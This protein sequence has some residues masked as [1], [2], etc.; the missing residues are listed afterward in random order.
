MSSTSAALEEPAARRPDQTALIQGTR[1]RSFSR[2]AEEA[3]AFAAAMQSNW[4][5]ER[6][7]V[8]AVY[9]PNCIEFVIAYFAAGMIGATVVPIDERLKRDEVGHILRDSGA[10]FAIVHAKLASRL[11]DCLKDGIPLDGIRGIG[12][13]D[14]DV[15]DMTDWLTV[16]AAPTGSAPDSSDIAEILYTSGTTGAAKGV[17]RTHGNVRAASRNARQAFGYT[18]SDVIAVIMPMTHSSALVSQMLPMIEAGGTAVLFESFD[19]RS[20]IDSMSVHQVSCMR[21]VPALFRM[22]LSHSEFQSDNLPALRLL[23]NSSAAID[24][25]TWNDLRTRFPNAAIMNSYGLTEASTC[26]ILSHSDAARYPDAIG[27]PIDSVAMRVVTDN[28]QTA[29]PG[30]IGELRVKGPHV[31]LGY[32]NQP[33]ATAAAMDE[34]GWLRTGDLGCCNDDGLYFFSGRSDDIIN[35]GGHKYAPQEIENCIARFPD[36]EEVSVIAAS[37][38]VLG[39]VP[40]AYVVIRAGATADGRQIKR[41]CARSLPSHKV[42]FFVEIVDDLP[43]NS[44]GKI[45]T[46]ELRATEVL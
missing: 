27:R 37:H 7:D 28:N 26:T 13:Q 21:A 17:M 25:E 41:H 34:D 23:M 39:Q 1:S 44:M 24:V 14:S 4:Q 18:D 11:G 45:L 3:R 20:V 42:P 46:R 5:V 30:E 6:G 31:F 40:K 9:S 8:I 35:C 15:P 43:R 38:R 19:S 33:D 10:R 12:T 16:G 32:R 29:A 22:L 36:V 2:L